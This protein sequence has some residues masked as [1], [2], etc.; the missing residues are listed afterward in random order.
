MKNVLAEM[1]N[2]LSEHKIIKDTEGKRKKIRELKD[3]RLFRPK[4]KDKM[5]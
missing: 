4:Y 5:D 2:S 3:I 1:K